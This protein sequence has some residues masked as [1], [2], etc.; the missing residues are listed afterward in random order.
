[1][2]DVNDIPVQQ[3]TYIKQHLTECSPQEG[4][5]LLVN[6]G[7]VPEYWPVINSA[8]DKMNSFRIAP[9]E[10]AEAEDAGNIVAVIHSHPGADGLAYPSHPR[11][12][13]HAGNLLTVVHLRPGQ[14]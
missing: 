3:L 1:M 9:Q 2:I 8:A 7:G 11:S 12:P 5:G 10:F 4:C 13:A 6:S 14:G